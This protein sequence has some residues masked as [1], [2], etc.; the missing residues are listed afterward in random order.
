MAA[1]LVDEGIGQH[2]VDRLVAQG[3]IAIHWLAIGRKGAEDS[4]VFFEAQQRSLTVFT[5]NR[6]DYTLLAA[7]WQNWNL[8]DHRGVIAPRKHKTQIP[9]SQLYPIMALFCADTSSFVN[10]IELF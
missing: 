8:G 6:D 5:H 3:F 10:R 7:A 9:P 4:V 1:L 2:L